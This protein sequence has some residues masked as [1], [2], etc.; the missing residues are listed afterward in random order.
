[1]S[2]KRAPKEATEWSVVKP[3]HAPVTDAQG[4][5]RKRF[6]NRQSTAA[7]LETLSAE[8]LGELEA[9][10]AVIRVPVGAATPL[11][12]VGSTLQGSEETE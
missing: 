2:G 4:R 10:G 8:K 1:M 9:A 7:D 5:T 12:A 11:P 6:F 3:F